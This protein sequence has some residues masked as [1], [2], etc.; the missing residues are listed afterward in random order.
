MGFWGKYKLKMFFPLIIIAGVSLNCLVFVLISKFAFKKPV[1]WSFLHQR[2]VSFSFQTILSCFTLLISGAV[3]PLICLNQSDGS[4]IMVRNPSAKCKTGEWNDN[5]GMVIFFLVLYT[6]ILPV[7]FGALLVHYRHCLNDPVIHG[8]FGS[9]TKSFK[10]QYFF[11]ELFLLTKRGL[12][13]VIAAFIPA[14]PGDTTFYF[15]C[16]LVIFSY[17]GLEFIFHPFLQDYVARRS[18]IW[19]L[20]TVLVLMSDS[21]VFKS[22]GTTAETKYA[23]SVVMLVLI[24]MA[25]SSM[26]TQCAGRLRR[27]RKQ[28]NSEEPPLGDMSTD[29]RRVEKCTNPEILSKLQEMVEFKHVTVQAVMLRHPHQP[30]GAISEFE[31]SSRGLP[32]PF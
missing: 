18:A 12:F 25:I 10:P 1:E 20:L 5:L 23:F 32:I 26:F 13:V 2:A 11:W 21:L 14:F 3:S 17:L 15:G 6:I 8:Y 31:Q 7:A 24:I 4:Q 30:V 19:S 16:I 28:T 9:F 22:S 27:K 29:P